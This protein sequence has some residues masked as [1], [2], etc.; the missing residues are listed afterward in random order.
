MLMK[1]TIDLHYNLLAFI[2][3]YC[4]GKTINKVVSLALVN[5]VAKR[6]EN[7]L[8]IKLNTEDEN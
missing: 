4:K 5:Y 8:N 7:N 1:M 3:K 6:E 2:K